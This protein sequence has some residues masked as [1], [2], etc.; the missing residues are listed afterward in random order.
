MMWSRNGALR[1]T[2][3]LG[4]LVVSPII[5][6]ATALAQPPTPLPESSRYSGIDLVVLIDQSGSMWGHPE[7][8]PEANDLR[9][10]R[11]GETQS[12]IQR[13]AAHARSTATVHRVSVVDFGDEAKVAI[14][15]LVMRYDRDNPDD[16]ETRQPPQLNGR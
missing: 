12:L 2:V 13:L 3:V 5:L 4:L 1:R 15:N 10:H 11:I 6:G 16:L 7:Y 14:S 8:H 9:G